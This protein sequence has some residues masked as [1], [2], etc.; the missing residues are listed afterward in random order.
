MANLKTD[1][2]KNKS[3]KS[4]SRGFNPGK[5]PVTHGP[6]NSDFNNKVGA[7]P[8]PN[9]DKNKTYEKRMVTP[10]DPVLNAVSMPNNNKGSRVNKGVLSFQGSGPVGANG[11]AG[12][13]PVGG[14]PK[15]NSIS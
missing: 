5:E 14:T 15:P 9:M 3:N 1:I 6:D 2:D 11:A 10:K 13:V 7:V 8:E 12:M 4:N